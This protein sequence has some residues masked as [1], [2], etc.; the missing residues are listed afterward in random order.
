MK[1][2]FQNKKR[3]T[4]IYALMALWFVA[5][6]IITGTIAMTPWSLIL[7]FFGLLAVPGFAL[8]QLF[9]IKLQTGFDQLMIWLTLGLIFGLVVCSVAMVSGLTVFNLILM[10]LIGIGA[11]LIASFV[12]DLRHESAIETPIEW[13]WRQ[14]FNGN[15]LGYLIIIVI[16]GIIVAGVGIQGTLFRGA[17]ANFHLSILRKAFEIDPLTPQNLSFI[18]SKTIHVAYGLPIWHIFLGM[19]AR[20][21]Q[22]DPFLIWKAISM[23][24]SILAVLVW[25]WLAKIIFNNRFMAYVALAVFLNYIFNWNTGY[26]FTLLPFPDSLNNYLILPLAIALLLKYVFGPSTHKFGDW[27]LLI[28]FVIFNLLM[29][30]IHITQYLYLMIMTGILGVLWLF[31]WRSPDFKPVLKKIGL[32]LGANI[33]LFLPFLAYVE[34]KSHMLSDVLVSLWKYDDPRKLRYIAFD[35]INYFGKWA[36]VLVLPTLIFVRRQRAI[37]FLLVMYVFLALTFIYPI[38]HFLV[39]VFGYIFVSRIFGS[40]VWHFLILAAIYGFL[41]L[42]LDRVLSLLPKIWR[43]AINII[44]VLGAAVLIWAEVK[45]TLAGRAYEWMFSKVVDNWFNAYYLWAIGVLAIITIA[46][47]ILQWRKPKTIE[48]F[49]FHEPKNGLMASS[50]IIVLIVI[51]FGTT[52]SYGWDYTKLTAQSAFLLKPVSMVD[53]RTGGSNMESVIRGVGGHDMVEFV[54]TNVPTK[55]VFLVPGSVINTF[56][57]ILDQYMIAYPRKKIVAQTQKIY[58]AKN[59]ISLEDGLKMLTSTKVQ[60]ILLTDAPDQNQAFFDKYP[61]HFEKIFPASAADGDGDSVIYKV[62]P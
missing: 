39:R 54:Q 56:S 11:L 53:V 49:Q 43:W 50:L 19:L 8:A 41:I 13:D 9:K 44:F 31:N 38:S 47:L 32:A 6:L 27:K 21:M 48:W 22:S 16:A 37:L 26:L 5:I 25:G 35:K 42:L 10:Y 45:F 40:I 23:P 46:I 18:K 12:I 60:Y 59:Q 3:L 20:L 2:Y 57:T 1:K 28:V 14:I 55:S 29:V 36:Y 51:L 61:D 7:V 30:N 15:N 34:V 24:L 17:D 62:K 58:S 52:Y 4:I 33:I